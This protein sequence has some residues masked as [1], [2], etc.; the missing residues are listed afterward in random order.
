MNN[1]S[2]SGPDDPREATGALTSMP[3]AL[4]LDAA[5]YAP[6]VDDFDITDDQK[7]ELL[8]TLWAIMRSFVELGFSVGAAD[9]CAQLFEE[10]N[11]ASGNPPEGVHSSHSSTPETLSHREGKDGPHE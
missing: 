5:K 4:E 1:P 11:A 8:K 9:I 6:Y 7:Q 10:F 2:V 3:A